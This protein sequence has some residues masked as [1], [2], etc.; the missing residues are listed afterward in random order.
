VRGEGRVCA[1]TKG[2]GKKGRGGGGS[3]GGR[4]KRFGG[5]I[6]EG[7]AIP[8]GAF[9]ALAGPSARSGDR[10]GREAR[11]K[12]RVTPATPPL[13]CGNCDSDF[14]RARSVQRRRTHGS[15]QIPFVLTP[16]VMTAGAPLS[17][18]NQ[19]RM[20]FGYLLP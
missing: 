7:A 13:I 4:E 14:G 8:I 3:G 5:P 20:R 6:V 9:E 2:E 15:T 18:S 19:I 16:N 12:K 10:S 1:D 11:T 17:R